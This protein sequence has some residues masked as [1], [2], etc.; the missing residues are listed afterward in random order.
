V[1]DATN[2]F[3]R[4]QPFNQLDGPS[5]AL[6][7]GVTWIT[8]ATGRDADGSLGWAKGWAKVAT[9]EAELKLKAA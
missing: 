9:L 4:C 3:S 5:D 8:S 6:I 2:E 7:H 1:I